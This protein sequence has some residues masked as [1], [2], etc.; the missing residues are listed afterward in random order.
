MC[1]YSSPVLID[2]QGADLG[3]DWCLFFLF[4]FNVRGT[5]R[6]CVS[7]SFFFFFHSCILIIILR[8]KASFAGG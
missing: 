3:A 2:C 4:L 5:D 7:F 8:R 6:I 1:K